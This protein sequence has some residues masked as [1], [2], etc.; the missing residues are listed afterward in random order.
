MLNIY[1]WMNIWLKLSGATEVMEDKAMTPFFLNSEYLSYYDANKSYSSGLLRY[2]H[3][4]HRTLEVFC[5]LDDSA[6]DTHRATSPPYIW[7]WCVGKI[8][9]LILSRICP[10]ESDNALFGTSGLFYLTKH[11]QT[12]GL[13][14]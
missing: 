14:S 3:S 1:F 6:R 2:V 5:A 8:L 4:L 12:D 10:T 7:V 13:T 9:N 11:P